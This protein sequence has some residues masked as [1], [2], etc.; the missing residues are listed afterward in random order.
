MKTICFKIEPE[1]YDKIE[2]GRGE[3]SRSDF[4]RDTLLLHFSQKGNTDI[5]GYNEVLQA[6]NDKLKSDMQKLE[7]VYNV[8]IDRIKDLQTQVGFLQLEY[9]KMSDRLMLPAAKSWWQFWK[10]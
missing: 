2:V 8:Q 9:Q 3:K 10:K 7:A 6:E 4:L 5:T 1:L